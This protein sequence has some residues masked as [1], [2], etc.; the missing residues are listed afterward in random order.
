MKFVDKREDG[1]WH[2]TGKKEKTGR[3][4]FWFQRKDWLAHRLMYWHCYGELT[5]ELLICHS[6][7]NQCVNPEHLEEGTAAKNSGVDKL[8]DGTDCRGEKHPMTKF[9]EAQVRE[10]RRRSCSESCKTLGDE[11]GVD[12]TTI[13]KIVNRHSWKYLPDN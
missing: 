7:R 9:T 10:I 4:Y 13:S 3:G 12:R 1:C 2:W 11:F 6:C 5:E 8:R